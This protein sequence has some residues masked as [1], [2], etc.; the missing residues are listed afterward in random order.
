MAL[1]S[2]IGGSPRLARRGPALLAL[3]VA[4]LFPVLTAAQAERV[5]ARLLVREPEIDFGDIIRGKAIEA[6]FKLENIGTE[7]LKV[8]RAQPG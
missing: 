1:E 7:P 6:T 2:N 8:L 3:A 5:G 4:G